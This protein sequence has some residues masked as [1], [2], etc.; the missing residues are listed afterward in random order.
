VA[1]INVCF[2]GKFLLLNRNNNQ[3]L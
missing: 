3:T 2:S 1:T